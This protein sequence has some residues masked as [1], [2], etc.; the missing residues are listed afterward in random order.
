MQKIC[1]LITREL[2]TN[3]SSFPSFPRK[4]LGMCE[5]GL[6]GMEINYSFFSSLFF[7]FFFFRGNVRIGQDFFPRK[8]P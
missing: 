1:A 3:L 4:I 2:I 8:T 6:R 7:S 5:G